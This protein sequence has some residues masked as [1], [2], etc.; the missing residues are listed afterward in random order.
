MRSS[1]DFSIPLA[2][3][4]NQGIAIK[5]ASLN[6]STGAAPDGHLAEA[7]V[8]Q[9]MVELLTVHLPSADMI[10]Q[11][12]KMVEHH[13]L[14]GCIPDVI[15]NNVGDGVWGMF[16]IKTLLADDQLGVAG[17]VRDLEKLCAYKAKYPK[18]AAV[19]LLVG[20]RAK[21]FNPNRTAAWSDLKISYDHDSFSGGSLKQQAVNE[22][23]VAIPCGSYNVEGFP[24]VC[25][26]WEIQ[27]VGQ[28]LQT[29]SSFFSYQARMI[30]AKGG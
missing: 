4:L 17:V 10:K 14:G 27:P 12:E 6:T 5:V 3:L 8:Q 28:T 18:A 11:N 1:R 2:K 20:S 15:V 16:E 22:K 25:F 26:M 29:L 19:F 30:R 7:C 13:R 23:Y 9:A 24:T 21:L